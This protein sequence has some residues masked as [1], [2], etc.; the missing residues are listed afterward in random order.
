MRSERRK[1]DLGE[2]IRNAASGYAVAVLSVVCLV[3][4]LIIITGIVRFIIGASTGTGV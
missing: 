4:F 1:E 2:T 3:L